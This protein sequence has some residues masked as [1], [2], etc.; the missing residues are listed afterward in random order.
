MAKRLAI[1]SD[2]HANLP[3]MEVVADYIRSGG[4]DGVY[5]LGDLGGYAS[6]PNEVQDIVQSMGCPT[7]LGNYDE[8]VGFERESCGCNYIQPFDIKMSDVS[9]FWTREHTSGEHKAWL[10]ELPRQIRLQVGDLDVLLCHGS[11]ASTTE[12]LFETRSDA[13]LNKFT[14]GGRDDAQADVIVFGHTHVP[15]HREVSGVHFVNTGS[16]G[17]PKDGDPRAGYCVLTIDGD[18]VSVEQIRLAYDIEAACMRLI[19]AGLP[20]YFADYLR[21]AGSV[22]PPE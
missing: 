9:F 14:V 5:C 21:L 10:R 1:F 22:T 13:Y 6:Q 19:A 11:P 7:I 18:Q 12:Y 3:A 8:G 17:R 20:E 16:V 15:F 4:Y 2:I